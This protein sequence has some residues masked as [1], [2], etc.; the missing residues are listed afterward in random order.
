MRIP[1]EP[2]RHDRLQFGPHPTFDA[3]QRNGLI[4][5]FA[6]AQAAIKESK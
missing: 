4:F 3:Y 1:T 5:R 2:F 6:T